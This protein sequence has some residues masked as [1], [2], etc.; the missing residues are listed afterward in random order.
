MVTTKRPIRRPTDYIFY[1]LAL[2]RKSFPTPPTEE[3]KPLYSIC[4]KLVVP[5]ATF[6][7][8]TFKVLAGRMDSFCAYLQ[9]ST[10]GD[11][12]VSLLIFL[13]EFFVVLRPSSDCLALAQAAQYWK[14]YRMGIELQRQSTTNRIWKSVILL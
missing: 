1:C 8:P 9:G 13:R 7:W 12:L 5:N 10:T 11:L 2:Y 4:R 6:P 14:K 3:N